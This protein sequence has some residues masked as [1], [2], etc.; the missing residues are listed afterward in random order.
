MDE[1]NT[2]APQENEAL[3]DSKE[4]LEKD[5][6]SKKE[7]EQNE[8]AAKYSDADLDK[9]IN[10]KFAEWKAKEE[11]AVKEAERLAKMTAAEKAEH[12]MNEAIKRAEEAEAKLNRYAMKSEARTI[13]SE[14]K[15]N[16]PESLLDILISDDAESTKT[17]IDDFTKLFNEAVETAV[18]AKIAGNPPKTKSGAA[19]TMSKEEIMAIKDPIA[20]RKA[21]AENIELFN[22]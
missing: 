19:A 10:K 1:K 2:N 22:I 17:R 18:K 3:K 7:P 14:A 15:L 16:L 8:N 13:L 21:I 4:T 20:R 9:I 12:Q 5:I 6:N 11:K